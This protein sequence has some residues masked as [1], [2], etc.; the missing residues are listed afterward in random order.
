MFS[1]Y[2][3]TALR[4]LLRQKSYTLINL[5]GLSV[6]IA[7]FLLIALYVQ[8]EYGFDKHLSKRDN[9]FRVVEIQ[10]EPG[11]GEQHVAITMGPLAGSLKADYPQVVDAVRFMPGFD[12]QVVSYGEKFFMERSLYYVDPSVID[13]FDIHFL[14]GDPK[15][16]LMEPMSVVLSEKTAI[17]YFGSV[18]NV[19]GKSMK[20]GKRSF[21]ITGIMEEQ[22][23]N[24]HMFFNILVSVSSVENLPDFEWMKGWGSNSLITYIQLDRPSSQEPIERAFPDFLKK[25]VFS[26][27]EGWEYLEMYLQPMN[28]VY[29]NSQHIKFQS[30]SASGD[31]NL[32]IAFSVIAILILLVACVNYINISIARSVKRSREV[33]IRKVLGA[34]RLSLIYQ[35]INESFLLTL[36]ATII[37]VGMVELTLPEMNK[38]LATDFRL[39]FRDNYLFNAGLFA[40]LIVISLA[41]GSYP[42]FYLSRLQPVHILKG[43]KSAKGNS[44]GY[45]SKGLVVFQFIISVGLMFALLVIHDQVKFM[46]KKDLGISYRDAVFLPFGDDESGEHFEPLKAELLKNP[47]IKSVSGSSFINGV[48]GSQGPVFVDDSAKTKLTVRFGYVDYDFF[49]AMGVSFA[50]GRNFDRKIASDKGAAVIINQAAAR[51]LGWDNPVGKKFKPIMGADTTTKTEVIGVINDYHY[52]SMRSLIEPAVY[53]MAPDRFRGLVIGYYPRA[54]QQKVLKFIEDKWRSYFPGTPFQP[55]LAS[56]YAAGSYKNDQKLFSLFV[57][58]TIISGLLSVLGLF[59]LT[60]L[61]IEQKTKIIGIRR[62]LGG[63]VWIITARLIRDYMILVLLAGLISLPVS[64]YLLDQQ[65]AQF[66]YRIHISAFHM[67]LSVVLLSAIA[68]LTIVFKAYRA[69]KANPVE[70]LKYE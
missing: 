48:S 57:Y 19:T 55:V 22:P 15:T 58:F 59:G 64:Y 49:E 25:H 30:V 62:V 65:L 52:Y 6:G 34:N 67:I 5:A 44:N 2:L 28:E 17:K 56:E 23:Q 46:Q 27:E 8:H 40:L 42:A 61:L 4:N 50:S 1:N 37:A 35:F 45:L 53:I 21:L 11:V 10:N 14:A 7:S 24:T 54:D 12:I 60:S 33:G 20:L 51:K 38:L 26:Q 36:L 9:L 31:I 3:T 68:F 29:L 32:V 16:A 39:D 70:A 41:S 66:A 13:M 47:E 18:N 69:A 63:P 43:G